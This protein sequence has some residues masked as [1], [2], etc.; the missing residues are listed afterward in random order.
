MVV[1]VDRTE[2]E[3]NQLC[4]CKYK[5]TTDLGYNSIPKYFWRG[6][7]SKLAAPMHWIATIQLM[8]S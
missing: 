5:F 7:A 8:I 4:M 6:V 1:V 3:L 2:I